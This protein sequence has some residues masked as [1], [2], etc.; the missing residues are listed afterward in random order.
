MRAPRSFKAIVKVSLFA[1]A[2]LALYHLAPVL[3]SPASSRR[4]ANGGAYPT[5]DPLLRRKPLPAQAQPTQRPG[6]D[7]EAEKRRWGEAQARGMRDAAGRAGTGDGD[8]AGDGR[9]WAQQGG[10]VPPRRGAP[11]RPDADADADA[12]TKPQP[13]R[14]VGLRPPGAARNAAVEARRKLAA[15]RARA[16]ERE[17]EDDAAA[18]IAAVRAAKAGGAGG[19]RRGALLAGGRRAGARAGGGKAQGNDEQ[20]DGA[21]F[22]AELAIAAARKAR[23]R[24]K[25]REWDERVAGAEAEGQAQVQEQARARGA[26]GR[27]PPENA[28]APL[29]RAQRVAAAVRE[30]QQQRFGDDEGDSL[31]DE[32]GELDAAPRGAGAGSRRKKGP[33]GVVAAKAAGAIAGDSDDALVAKQQAAAAAAAGA[34]EREGGG[35]GQRFKKPAPP[36]AQPAADADALLYDPDSDLEERDTE[37]VRCRPSPPFIVG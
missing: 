5:P 9:K 20:D 27:L 37:C 24:E 8:G 26:A 23:A 19:D 13:A 31:V 18:A 28:R 21:T 3:F 29:D 4:P 11:L 35:W 33:L 17:R 22:E 7:Y 12:G 1:L 16:R 25:L 14:V 32:D 36:A 34:K 30:Q 2:L 10:R 6:F 15:E